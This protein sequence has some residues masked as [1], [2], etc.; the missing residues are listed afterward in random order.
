MA[1]HRQFDEN[2]D[3]V[4]IARSR[5]SGSRRPGRGARCA[6]PCPTT[7]QVPSETS[8]CSPR[9]CVSPVRHPR[10]LIRFWFLGGPG[11][12]NGE[13]WLG[14]GK[15]LHPTAFRGGTSG[16]EVSSL[17]SMESA[18]L[19]ARAWPVIGREFELAQIADAR[20]AGARAVVVLAPAGM[21]KSRLAREAL[22]RGERDGAY[23]TWAQATR[24]A[25]TV[26][27]GAFAG[28]IPAE[29]RSTIRSSC[30]GGPRRRCASS[31][32]SAGW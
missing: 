28:V 8:T 22:A 25:A 11:A 17:A 10:G 31:P 20:A 2:G 19:A 26:P 1:R 29:V 24:S 5:R 4:R 3:V 23:T 14:C 15:A 6:S 16:A 13:Q 7:R 12:R 27:L 18:S 9:P 32:A 21:G 30:C